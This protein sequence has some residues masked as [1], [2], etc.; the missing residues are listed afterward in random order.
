MQVQAV[1]LQQE[2]EKS[3]EWHTE[4]SLIEHRTLHDVSPTRIGHVGSLGTGQVAN[5]SAVIYP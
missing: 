4:S 2:A 1:E 5:S 3:V